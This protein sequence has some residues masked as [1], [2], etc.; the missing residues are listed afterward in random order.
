MFRTNLIRCVLA[1]A[2]VMNASAQKVDRTKPPETPPLAPFKL[3]PTFETKLGN[4]LEVVL[5][6]DARLPLVTLQLAFRA[7]AK[8]DPQGQPGLAEAVATLLTEGTSNRSARQIAEEGTSMGGS[9]SAGSS[10][11]GITISG[12]A[13]SE[14]IDRMLELTADVAR[15]AN[16]PADEI[17]L[18]QQNRKQRLLEQR[19]QAAFLA[20]EKLKEVVFGSHPY[21]Q[22]TPTPES[23]DKLNVKTLSQFRDSYLAPNNA[24]LIV[25]GKLPARAALLKTIESRF[26]AW[27]RREVPALRAA[28]PPPA[29]RKVVVVDRPGSVQADIHIGRVGPTRVE[30]DYFP[31]MVGSAV[32]GG[33]ASSRLFNE[34]REKKG[35]A[36]SVYTHQQPFKDSGLFETVMQ[37]RNEVAGDALNGMLAEMKKM[38]DEAV[39]GEELTAVK[40]NL[41]GIFVMRLERQEGLAAQL[42]NIKTMGLPNDYLETYTTRVRSTEP[43]QIQKAAKKYIAPDQATI[44]VV[45]DQT[46]IGETVQKFK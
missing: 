1:A 32:L 28:A 21:A 17:Q 43:D 38:G 29:A 40:N 15:N 4:G 20:G 36:Y 18:Y 9:V 24:V 10:L 30:A 2:A 37:V 42:A 12:S 46:K 39:S 23:I 13:L 11:D 35:Y 34:I 41:S 45:G 31:Y 6:E 8:N 27:Q 25:L 33:G 19:S 14:N 26:G 16:F 5:V 22:T 7:G 44:V 3:P